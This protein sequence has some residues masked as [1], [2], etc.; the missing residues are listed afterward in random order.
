[1]AMSLTPQ[2]V[3]TLVNLISDQITGQKALTSIDPSDFVS[4]GELL[5]STGSE[6][7]LNAITIVMG[8][9]IVA[10]RPYR[11]KLG[12]IDAVDN[13]IFTQRMRK[14][15]YY[16]QPA[17]ESGAWNTQV[18]TNFAPGY[19][20]GD[21]GGASQKSMWEQKPGMPVEVNFTSFN[22]WD[23]GLTR[24]EFQLENA[25]KSQDEFAR[26][27][28]GIYQEKIN[29]I[30]TQR[31]A[32]RRNT[33]LNYMAA[34]YDADALLAGTTMAV[35]LTAE[36]NTYM[37]NPS[38]ALTRTDILGPTYFKQFLEFFVSEIKKYSDYFE[39]RSVEYHWP[40]PKTVGGV[41]YN[42]LRHT[43]KDRQKLIL[44]RPLLLDAE[45]RIMP[46][47]FNDR[48]LKI[49]NYEGVNYWQ[50][51]ETLATRP[52]IDVDGPAIPD[53]AGGTGVQIKGSA[54]ALDYVVGVLFDT[55]ALWDINILERASATPWE[56]RKHYSNMWWTFSHGAISDVTEKG[57][58][59]YL[60]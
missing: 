40:M 18:Y 8:R 46:E 31:E 30:E 12:L 17:V 23:D 36:F 55:D 21:N 2:D 22:V 9:L 57:V 20:N 3:T 14:I 1:M 29:D 6:N 44:Y 33:L 39:E 38:P 59:F 16:S 26:F 48:Y 53:I 41:T 25:W 52:S 11:A 51:N 56:S 4:A 32:Y 28:E 37:G 50:T 13:G 35:D 42:I 19:D 24:F 45:S 34:L 47:I 7:V 5:M 27:I 54:V 58:L 15:S 60:G 43:P 49:D 10:S